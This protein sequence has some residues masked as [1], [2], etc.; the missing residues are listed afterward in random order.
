[1]LVPVSLAP[2]FFGE[3][4]LVFLT[5]AA[6]LGIWFLWESI[7]TARSRS[8]EMARRLLLASVIYLPLLLILM[9][10]DRK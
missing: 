1:M 8:N 7:R 9:V 10:I 4:G 2:F 6:L 3:A 5:G